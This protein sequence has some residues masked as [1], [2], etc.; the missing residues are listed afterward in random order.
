MD[1]VFWIGLLLGGLAGA[2]FDLWKRPLDR[3]LDRRLEHRTNSRIDLLAQ[4]AQASP[5]GLRVY[6]VEVILQTTLIGSLIGILVGLMYVANQG[7]S[8]FIA[9]QGQ[10]L[11]EYLWIIGTLAIIGQVL[12]ILGAGYIVRIAGDALSVSR[13]LNAFRAN[14]ES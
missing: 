1:G 5:D 14:E 2:A 12:S 8:Y 7:L 11:R 10:D 9:G 13:R 3:L 4:R 6:L